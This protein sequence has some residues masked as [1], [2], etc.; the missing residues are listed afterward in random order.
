M[1]VFLL[2]ILKA[3]LTESSYYVSE[4]HTQTHSVDVEGLSITESV[5]LIIK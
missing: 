2:G 1:N 3:N 4:L 5:I